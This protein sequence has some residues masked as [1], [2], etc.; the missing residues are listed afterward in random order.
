MFITEDLAQLTFGWSLDAKTSLRVAAGGILGGTLTGEIRGD[1]DVNPGWV[2][3]FQ[4]DRQLLNSDGWLPFVRTQV[5]VGVSK[6]STT[7]RSGAQRSVDNDFYA[8]D[9]RAGLTVGWPL[10]DRV[11]VYGATR[12][13][14]APFYWFVA[15]E[16]ESFSGQDINHYQVAVG[17]SLLV[18][19][20]W[21]LFADW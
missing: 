19:N 18:G 1:H 8:T 4:V 10:G 17:G 16:P 13:F 5:T 9:L 3:S 14:A 12:V 11:A 2:G 7:A 20:G 6:T 15:G 21:R